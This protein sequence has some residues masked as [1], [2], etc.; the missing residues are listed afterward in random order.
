MRA[1]KWEV[2]SK[3]DV[4]FFKQATNV[5]CGRISLL[6]AA[7]NVPFAVIECWRMLRVSDFYSIWTRSNATLLA[8]PADTV[9][10][11]CIWKANDANT[12]AV[13]HPPRGQ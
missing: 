4:V 8:I 5:L 3:G 9:M 10:A 11:A 2:V 12:I 7:D 13:L 1:N 6:C